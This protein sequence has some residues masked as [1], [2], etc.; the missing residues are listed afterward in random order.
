MPAHVQRPVIVNAPHRITTH[1]LLEGIRAHTADPVTGADHPRLRV[2]QR[3]IDNSGVQYRYWSRPFDEATAAVGVAHRSRNAFDD[4]LAMA[5]QAARQALADAR[6]EPGQVDAI[7]TSHTTSFTVPGLDVHLVGA[8]GLR[9]DVVRMPIA[10]MACAGGA[11]ALIR[12]HGYTQAHP[13]ARVLVVVGEVPSTIYHRSETTDESMMYRALF[14]DSGSATVVT[15]ITPGNTDDLP[16][17]LRITGTLESVLPDSLD[18]YWGTVDADGLHFLSTKAAARAAADALPNLRDWLGDTA[19]EWVIV[20]PGGPGIVRD[21]VAGL[22]L[23]PDKAGRHSYASLRSGNRGGSAV[24]DV[25]ARTHDDP[26]APGSPGVL[27]AYGPGFITA[28]LRGVW[29]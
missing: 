19:P 20:H 5:A 9:H 17:G 8:L 22:G 21:T 24:L 15:G 29:G 2:W 12:A 1:E 28:A 16:P 11:Q 27:T 25:L 4:A 6:L 26:P 23:D 14:G 18:R 10:T 13:G 7:V 3:Y